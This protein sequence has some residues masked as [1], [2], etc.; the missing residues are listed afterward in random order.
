VKNDVLTRHDYPNPATRKTVS[1][2]RINE[3]KR[4]S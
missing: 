1:G 4:P 2:L 3:G